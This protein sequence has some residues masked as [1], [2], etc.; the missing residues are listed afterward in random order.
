MLSSRTGIA[1]RDQIEKELA[2]ALAH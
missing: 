1:S 2:D